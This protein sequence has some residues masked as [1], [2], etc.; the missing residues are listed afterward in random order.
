MGPG[1]KVTDDRVEPL[2]LFEHRPV[3]GIADHGEAAVQRQFAG[4]ATDTGLG[5][6]VLMASAVCSFSP[7]SA[8]E[9]KEVIALL[10]TIERVS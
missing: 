3:T 10:R 9:A 6:R 1:E 5:R 8:E 2:G 7:R 4:T